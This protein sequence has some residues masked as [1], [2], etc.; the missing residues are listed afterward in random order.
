MAEI[1]S[2]TPTISKSVKTTPKPNIASPFSLVRPKKNTQSTHMAHPESQPIRKPIYVPFDN[3]YDIEQSDDDEKKNQ[4]RFQSPEETP[5]MEAENRVDTGP[6][7]FQLNSMSH[8]ESEFK[9]ISRAL[10]RSS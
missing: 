8:I 9:P 10:R 7:R 6:V 4:Q 2:K 3:D 5:S 1:P